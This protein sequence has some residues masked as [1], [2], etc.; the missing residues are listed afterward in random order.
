MDVQLLLTALLLGIVE[1]LTEFL[2]ISST[3]HLIIVG[4]LLGYNDEASTVFKIVIQFAAILAVCWEY[5]ERLIKVAVGLPR[6]REA[7]RFVGLLFLGFLPAAVLGL[8]FHSVIK[9]VLFNPLT[10]AT[11]LVVGGLIILYVE[12]RAYRPRID[13]VEK[14]GWADAVK[15][16]F[17]QALAMIPGTSRS[18]STIMGGLI[19]GLSRKTAAEFSFFLAIPTMFAATVYD[20]YK[21]WGLLHAQDLPVFAI[22]FVASFLSA[23]VAVKTFIRFISNHTFIGFAWYRI[24]FGLIVLASWQ[25]GLVDW[26]EPS[27]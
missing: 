10:V 4:D 9:T 22:G 14:M 7:Q 23:M 19:F 1:G 13:A 25:F 16:G 2:P 20:L 12:K 21:N 6:E 15:I 26:S 11:A 3:G 18:G 17:A 27:F 24:V 5:R 8:M